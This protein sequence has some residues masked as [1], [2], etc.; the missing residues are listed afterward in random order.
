LA[1]AHSG[2]VAAGRAGRAARGDVLGVLEAGLAQVG[3]QVD[4]AGGDPQPVAVD[5]LG[6]AG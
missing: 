2:G 3:V 6:V 5:H 4:Q 1:I